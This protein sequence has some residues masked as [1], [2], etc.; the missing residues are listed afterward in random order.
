MSKQQPEVKCNLNELKY[1]KS[2]ILSDPGLPASL[3]VCML[4]VFI[5]CLMRPGLPAS[6]CVYVVCLHPVSYAPRIAG[7]TVCV[8]V[9]CLH[10][11][12]PAILGA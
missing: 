10:P 6:L 7:F 9:V 11:V 2:N 12:K 4:F 1:I 3:C 5:L 8:Y